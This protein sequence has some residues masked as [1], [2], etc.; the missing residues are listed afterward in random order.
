M[1][2]RKDQSA[3]RPWLVGAI[4][5]A[6]LASLGCSG[7]DDGELGPPTP[8]FRFEPPPGSVTATVFTPIEF[9][10]TDEEARPVTAS[11]R[12]DGVLAKTA[13]TFVWQGTRIGV[14]EISATVEGATD[15][16]TAQWTVQVTE[17]G[18]KATPAVIV[19]SARE[20]AVPGS[21]DVTWEAPPPSLY[22][23]PLASYQ[24]GYALHLIED[25][26]FDAIESVVVEHDSLQIVQRHRLEGLLER[27]RYYVRVR[28]RDVLGRGSELSPERETES[29]GH[30]DV[31]GTITV[32][33]R[34][35]LERPLAN[36]LVELGGTKDFT[37]GDGR[38]ELWNLP[39]LRGGPMLVREDTGF[40]YYA[41]QTDSLPPQDQVLDFALFPREFV[42]YPTGSGEDVTVSMVDFLRRMTNNLGPESPQVYG[43]DQYPVPVY[44]HPY[45]NEEGVDYG[46]AMAEAVRVWN[47]AAGEDMLRAVERQAGDPVGTGIYYDTNLP[48]GGVLAGHTE[49]VVPSNGRLYETIPERVKISLQSR[50]AS[51]E[52]VNRLMAHEVGH[53]LFISHSNGVEHIMH[54]SV[55]SVTEGKPHPDEAY[56]VRLVAHL[57][58]GFDSSWIV[59]PEPSP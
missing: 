20:G 23:V 3:R 28:V 9:R 37:A 48:V 30:F 51:Q 11:F 49:V 53:A 55:P 34:S 54:P 21:V 56:V 26:N 2:V 32:L 41:V 4:A 59:D 25:E 40:T 18:A 22:T 44:I 33:D 31:Q 6:F 27:Q 50:F 14:V 52:Y 7:G 29:T 39:D 24:V 35:P 1:T 13:T 19:L 16:G 43:W 47:A 57:P 10:V 12:V 46:F 42:T 36:V 58:Q 15:E 5:Y 38:Y 45:V 8:G 17:E